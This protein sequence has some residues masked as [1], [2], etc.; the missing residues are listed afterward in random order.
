MRCTNC[1]V[2]LV[3]GSAFCA[4]CGK[5]AGQSSAATPSAVKGTGLPPNIAGMLSYLLGFITGIF[6]LVVDPYKR[7]SF[8]RFHAFQAIFLSIAWFAAYFVV[9]ALI[10]IAPY[11]FWQLA[12]MLHS[13]LSFAFFLLWVFLMYKAYSHEQFK[14][15]FIG[16]LAAKQA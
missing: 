13:L 11:T 9:G 10:S 2:D 16:E 4:S 8:V 5:P 7:D 14:L 3:E 12:W 15:P 6:F 1:G